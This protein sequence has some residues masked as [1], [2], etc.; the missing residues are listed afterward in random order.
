MRKAFCTAVITPEYK[1]ILESHLEVRYGG[2]PQERRYLTEAQLIEE[3]KDTDVLILGYEKLTENVIKNAPSLKLVASERDGPEENIDVGACT[4]AGI[5]VVHSCG[6]CINPVG[7]H[8]FTLMLALA[9]QFVTEVN[10][11]REGYWNPEEPEKMQKLMRIVDFGVDELYGATL[12][13]VG[14]GRNGMNIAERGVAFGMEVIGFD[15][16]A[17]AEYAASKGIRLVSLEEVMKQS[18]Y[19]VIM[20][21]VCPE[22]VGMIGRREIALMKP[23]A[24]FINTARAQLVDYDALYDAL[25]EGRLA[26]AALDVF[27]KEP[28]APDSRW[29]AIDP[30]KLILTPHQAG[31]SRQRDR[32]HS[33]EIVKY[34]TQYLKGEVPSSIMDKAVFE[35]PGFQDRGAR[36]FG[37]EK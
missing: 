32:S 25:K 31:I 29:F 3:L 34:I 16:Y 20:A 21:R 36:L 27:E 22:T 19:F 26:G 13:V 35:V 14:L 30:S 10:L 15:P 28:L 7:E 5:P 6:R 17:D 37:I 8:T 4:R 11:V 12:G 18:D 1:K 33:K 24:R 23:T 9:R 2:N